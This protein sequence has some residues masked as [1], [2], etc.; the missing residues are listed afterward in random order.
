MSSVS[1]RVLDGVARVSLGHFP[2]PLERLDRLTD[3]L[4]GPEIWIK[5]DDC[6]GLAT[7]GNKT[8]KLEFIVAAAKAQ[9]CDTLVT[10]GRLQSN[11]ARQTAAAAARAG[12]SC[13]L[14]LEVLEANQTTTYAT[15]G[16][17]LLDQM[18]GA[19]VVVVG[20]GGRTDAFVEA[21]L[22]SLIADGR[23][24]YLVPVGGSDAIGATG[25]V[26]CALEIDDQLRKLNLHVDHIV[27]ATASGGTQA[28]LLVG[29]H[30]AARNT[31]VVGYSVAHDAE[32][33]AH[34]VAGIVDACAAHL[35]VEA[36]SAQTVLVED[37][38][39]GPGYG[40]ADAGTIEAIELFART[41]G[42][43]LDPVYTGKA[44]AGLIYGCRSGRYA[45]DQRVVFLH[46]G[47]QS[48]TFGYAETLS[49]NGR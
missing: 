28:G 5:R 11:H 36:P 3:A 31:S 29:L 35:Q 9:G 42:I 16:N 45:A 43:I 20:P 30:A 25:Y 39:L 24:S 4:G 34:K 47:G 22:N 10:L 2:T 1:S 18:L 49:F 48:A 12:M 46:T 23:T 40:Q 15:N 27:T 26:C 33:Q 38:T 6:T 19:D 32:T 37:H 44:A 14:I 13:L 17:M 21:Q 7:G 8:R 41:E